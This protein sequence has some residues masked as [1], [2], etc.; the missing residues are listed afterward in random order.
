MGGTEEKPTTIVKI[1]K[2]NNLKKKAK[3]EEKAKK[4]V[5]TKIISKRAPRTKK[6]KLFEHTWC[7][8]AE[9]LKKKD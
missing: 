2:S 3:S 9:L 6:K 1:K 4:E 7:P 5:G 8:F